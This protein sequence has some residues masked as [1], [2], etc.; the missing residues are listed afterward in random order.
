MKN[1]L[2]VLVKR[3]DQGMERGIR[4]AAKMHGR[5]SF[6][7]RLGAV[8]VGGTLLPM[9]PFDRTFGADVGSAGQLDEK[10]CEYWA[11]CSLNGGR[12][13]ACGGTASQCPPGS[14]PSV[15]AWVGTCVNP[16][17]RKA[18]LVAYNDCCGKVEC[19]A[20]EDAVCSRHEGERPGYRLGSN[21]DANW[22]MANPNLSVSCSTAVIIGLAEGR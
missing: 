8:V 10:N 21:N 3:M 14:Q 15:V 17:D 6:L 18:Y 16:T 9:L 22:C 19:E 13:D 2:T 12:C 7:A 1:L 11:Y 20:P 5:R 4:C